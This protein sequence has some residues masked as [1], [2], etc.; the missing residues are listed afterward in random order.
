MVLLLA[1]QLL[2]TGWQQSRYAEL[3]QLEL[4]SDD[5]LESNARI[6]ENPPLEEEWENGH[7]IEYSQYTNLNSRNLLLDYHNLPVVFIDTS[8]PPP[9]L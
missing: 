4:L 5:D 9:N 7:S 1:V 6:L 8:T 2:G 3:V